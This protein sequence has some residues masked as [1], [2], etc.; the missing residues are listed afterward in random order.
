MKELK[1]KVCGMRDAHNIA[2]IAELLPDYLGFVFVP[3][4]P[5]DA[6]GVVSAETVSVLPEG[7]LPVGVFQ[8]AAPELLYETVSSL[9]LRAIQLHGSE[10]EE[11]VAGVREIMPDVALWRAV[12]VRSVEDVA[13]VADGGD[14]LDMYVLDSGR[15]GSGVPFDWSWLKEYRASTPFL[16][17]GGIGLENKDEA[18]EAARE[19]EQCVG[20]DVSSRLETKPGVKNVEMVRKLKKRMAA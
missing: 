14:L 6:T 2:A 3:G 17:A 5:R 4:S 19:A 12:T 16:L 10:D 15:G 9:G 8:D 7:V 18:I 20:L 1:L 13:A 11:Y